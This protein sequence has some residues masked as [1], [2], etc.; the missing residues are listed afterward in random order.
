MNA[1]SLIILLPVLFG[2]SQ[3]AAG[4]PDEEDAPKILKQVVETNRFWLD[5]RPKN[6]SYTLVVNKSGPG[7]RED[8]MVDKV[9]VSG[10]TV[11][12]G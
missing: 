2:F 12:V 10:D 8:R 5:P 4:D 11:R 6:L 7:G 1:R 3:V 9:F